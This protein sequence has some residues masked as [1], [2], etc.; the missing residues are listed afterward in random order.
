[1]LAVRLTCG[2][3]GGAIDF[4]RD[5]GRRRRVRARRPHGWVP[6]E[7]RARRCRHLKRESSLL[8]T[9]WSE[10]TFSS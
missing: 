9:Y 7:T 2:R 8:T 3:G 6:H 4:D 10:S 5:V 1:M